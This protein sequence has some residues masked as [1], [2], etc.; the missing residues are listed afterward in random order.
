MVLAEEQI[1]RSMKQYRQHRNTLTERQLLFDKD[2]KT[3][4]WMKVIFSTNG[5]RTIGYPQV[6]KKHYLNFIHYTETI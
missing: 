4:Q 6:K 2:G 3:I 5:A 1:Y